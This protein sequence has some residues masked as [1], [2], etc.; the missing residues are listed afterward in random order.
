MSNSVLEVLNV[1][2]GDCFILN[3][4]NC[5]YDDDIFLV[6]TGPGNYD[7]TKCFF[8]SDFNSIQLL[9]THHDN[10]HLGGFKFLLKPNLFHKVKKIHLP[11]YQNEITLI[12]ES[13]L[14]IRGI[15]NSFDCNEFI[16]ELEQ[17]VNNYIFLKTIESMSRGKIG[18]LCAEDVL[19]NHIK[20]LNPPNPLGLDVKNWI[21]KLSEGD[22]S[23]IA[24][25]IF[26][27][28][29]ATRINDYFKAL[30][31]GYA[32][33][34]SII[35]NELFIH[36]FEDHFNNYHN[37]DQIK[38]NFYISFVMNNL[39]EIRNFNYRPSRENMRII[40]NNFVACTHDVCLVLAAK[41][42]ETKFLLTGDASIR[43]FNIMINNGNDLSADFLK[44]PHHGSKYNLNSNIVNII[45]PKYAIIC[46]NN[47]KFGNSKDSHP[48]NEILSLLDKQ[49]I[50]ILITNDVIKDG[51][52]I[53]KKSNHCMDNS[54]VSIK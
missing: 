45:N 9:I 27:N 29:F 13:L 42:K 44:V 3:P 1:S 36:D 28:D 22:F 49:G 6:D 46:H 12:A 35:S 51:T 10:D 41:Y 38:G 21:D 32:S 34:D 52:V 26:T 25:E 24:Y 39:S 20:C 11:F 53:M 2:Q 14:N 7:F 54:L 37:E 33:S 23:K 15:I 31:G 50:Q 43:A 47:R 18:F 30:K 16:N 4:C 48:N 5:K 8:E 19:C 17:L 40:Y